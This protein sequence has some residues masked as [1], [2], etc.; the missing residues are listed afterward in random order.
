MDSFLLLLVVFLALLVVVLL[1][2]RA[3]DR[4]RQGLIRRRRQARA[5]EGEDE[6]EALLEEQGFE[7]LDR[8]V[9]RCWVV[10]VDGVEHEVEVRAD[11]LAEKGGRTWVVEVKTGD[12]APDPL[13]PATRR[14]LLEYG[15]VFG[16]GV[17]LL[18]A[19]AG[20]LV[21]VEFPGGCSGPARSSRGAA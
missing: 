12:V 14:Q 1:A 16:V 9:R 18:D 5:R 21:E 7:V 4:E 10:C 15:L 19:E 20:T 3:W 6:A 17:L 13:H 11:L 2:A 8:Q